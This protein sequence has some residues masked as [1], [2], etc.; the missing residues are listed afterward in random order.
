[1]PQPLRLEEFESPLEPADAADAGQLALEEVRLE[2]FESGYRAGWDDAMT[3]QAEEQGR[4]RADLARNLQALSFTYFEARAH[5]IRALAPLLREMAG[6]VMPAIARETLPALVAEALEGH[7][8]TAAARPMTLVVNPANRAAVEKAVTDSPL[9][10]TLI[11][12][13]SLGDGQVYLRFDET[14]ERIDIDAALAAIASAVSDYLATQDTPE[15]EK[16][17]HG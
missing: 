9:P 1:M 10:L 11:D 17:S 12:E 6:R 3:A 4:L 16:R 15:Q 5:V 13:P 2:A 8:E 14:E 7:A